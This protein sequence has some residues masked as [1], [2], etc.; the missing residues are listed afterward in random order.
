MTKLGY[1]LIGFKATSLDE[2]VSALENV[3]AVRFA[4]HESSYRG[5]DYARL[6]LADDESIIIQSNLELDD[7]LAE[8]DF[9]D[10]SVLVCID[11]TQRSTYW[12]DRVIQGVAGAEILRTETFDSAS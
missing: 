11:S 7:E 2:A 8:P 9:P 12:S 10:H 3:L 6:D 5:G 4:H 1:I